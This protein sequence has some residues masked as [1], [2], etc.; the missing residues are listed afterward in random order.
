MATP[1]LGSLLA[2]RRGVEPRNP[3]ALGAGIGAV[4]GAWASVLVDLWCPLT[5]LPHVL[6]G[7]VLPIVIL[8]ALSTVLGRT[9]LGVALI[10][11]DDARP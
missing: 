2:F 8:V 1:P 7:H 10:E 6:V 4:C 11:V 9:M 5:N 3:W